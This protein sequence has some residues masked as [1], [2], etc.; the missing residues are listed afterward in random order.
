GNLD[1][2]LR[3][4]D[5][6]DQASDPVFP[7]LGCSLKELESMNSVLV[8]GSN[9]RRAAP[10]LAHRVRKAA[11]AGASVSF[12]NPAKYE[13]LFP[14]A[15]YLTSNGSGMIDHLCSL[16]SAC[17]GVAPQSMASIVS[18]ARVSDAHRALIAQLKSGE[19]KLVLLGEIAQRDSDYS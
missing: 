14:V 8:I 3:R 19:K 15:S 9:L 6:R 11:V 13:Y 10:M 4:T 17:D 7:W 16:L 18:A 12:V 1:H 2:R 5:F